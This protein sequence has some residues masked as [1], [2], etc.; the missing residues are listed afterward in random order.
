MTYAELIQFLDTHLG[1]TLTS[2]RDLE[3]L[4][5]E[6]KAGKMEDPLAQEILVA[7]YSGNACDGIAAPVDRARS[8][9]GLAALRLRSQAD[10]SDPALFRKVL[11]LSETLDRA[12]DEEVIRQKA[13]QTH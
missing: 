9:D 2:G 7:I 5:A 4:L 3:A 11:K 12:F 10:D 13:A 1:Y 6:A 8:F